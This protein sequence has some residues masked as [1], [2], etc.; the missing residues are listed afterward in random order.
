MALQLNTLLTRGRA[1][2]ADG[3]FAVVPE[4]DPGG[5]GRLTGE[6]MTLAASGDMERARNG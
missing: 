5:G 4:K 1:R 6:I 2:A 3:T